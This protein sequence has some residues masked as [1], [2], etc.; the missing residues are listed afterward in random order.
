MFEG[1][2]VRF[3]RPNG[4]LMFICCAYKVGPIVAKLIMQR[5]RLRKS[6]FFFLVGCTVPNNVHSGSCRY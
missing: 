5:D 2:C 3:C 6:L 1:D 4:P